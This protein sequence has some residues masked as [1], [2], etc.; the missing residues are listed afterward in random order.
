MRFLRML[1][2]LMVIE[3]PVIVVAI[4]VVGGRGRVYHCHQH[5][6]SSKVL[7]TAVSFVAR[8]GCHK[9]QRLHGTENQELGEEC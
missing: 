8:K 5:P 4:S 7:I 3:V 2:D 6:S 9:C 1:H